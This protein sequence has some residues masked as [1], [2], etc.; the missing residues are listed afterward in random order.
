MDGS[1]HQLGFNGEALSVSIPDVWWCFWLRKMKWNSETLKLLFG[2]INFGS[3][4]VLKKF[5]CL[6]LIV[7]ELWYKTGEKWQ[8]QGMSAEFVD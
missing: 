6:L 5:S 7:I 8:R 3:Y 4:D 1:L 2:I